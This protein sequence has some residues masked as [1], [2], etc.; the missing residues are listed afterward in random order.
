MKKFL[1]TMLA[2][3][4]GLMTLS[5]G[6]SKIVVHRGHWNTP[7]SAQNSIASLVKADSVG[8]DGS[9]FDVY[10]TSDDVLVVNH[11]AVFQGYK[12]IDTPSSII[13]NLVLD[14]GEKLP[15]LRQYLEAAKDLNIDLFMELEWHQT[16]E[17]ER[18]VARAA[19]DMVNE[20]GLASRTN[21]LSFSPNICNELSKITD[22]PVLQ[23][24]GERFTPEQAKEMGSTGCDFSVDMWTK[25]PEYFDQ[26]RD[27]GLST[28]VWVIDDRKQLVNAMTKDFDFI[29]TN[30]PE[31]AL[32]LRKNLYAKPHSTDSRD[33]Q[34]VAHRGY[35]NTPGSAQNS[36]ASLV[37]ADSVGA[38]ATEFDVYMTSDDV[39][40]LN[41]DGV[42]NGYKIVETPSTII[43]EQTLENGEKLPT[44]RQFLEV[45]K[46]LDIDL[47]LELKWHPTP[48]R[49][50]QAAKACVDMINEFGLSPRTQYISFS[51]TICN[52]LAKHTD[53]PV[54]HL[55]GEQVAPDKAK[56]LGC[57]GCDYSAG[58]WK[59]NPAM[60]KQ[61]RDLD[62]LT[63]IWTIDDEKQLTYALKNGFDYITT[64]NPVLAKQ[65]REK[66]ASTSPTGAKRTKVVAH[67]GYWTVPGSAQNSIT[68]LVKADSVGADASEFDVYMTSDDVL[69]LNHDGL[70]N[71]HWVTST[72]S[73]II[74]EQTLE[75]GEKLPTLRQFLDVA[76]DLD[77]DLVL[78]VKGHSTPE[79]ERQVA[80]AC[81]DMINE[82]GLSHR[83]QYISFSSDVCEELAKHTDR[84]VSHLWGQKCPPAEAKA[85]GCT[86][87][88]YSYEAWEEMPEMYQ[89]CQDLGMLTNIWT[90]YDEPRMV[91]A[92]QDGMDFI[93]T[94][95]PEMAMKLRKQTQLDPPAEA[96]R[97]KVVAHRG[98]W[99]APG[100]AQN[101][102]R[103]LIK[104]DSIGADATEFDVWMCSDG[105]LVLN[106]DGVINGMSVQNT[107]SKI[108]RQQKLEN[109]ENVPTLE[110]FLKVA[111][112]L[113][114]DLVLEL[115][116]HEKPER[117]NEAIKKIMKLLKKNHLLD[118]TEFISFS[119]N[120]CREFSKVTDRPV[121][122]L[123]GQ[124]WSPEE[125]KANGCTGCDYAYDVWKSNPDY[126]QRC[127]DNGL[128]IN[129]WTL[130]TEKGIIE[131][132][133][134]GVDYMTTDT[135]ELAQEI[136]ARAYPEYRKACRNKSVREKK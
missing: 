43:C 45:A 13:C 83:T 97:P 121:L 119:E 69:V 59:S 49:E 86:G 15:T 24:W 133:N 128:A 68:S 78:E 60:F 106:H 25:Q 130:G 110:E 95:Y 116:V 90:V 8:A 55:W 81:V 16:P 5:A 27:L 62:L 127:R 57:T 70:I 63:N 51:S 92:F 96:K 17:R 117:E 99:A 104:A 103:S 101:S 2:A 74:C 135:P 41:H 36:I 79:R 109:G 88:D 113:D 91:K 23:L 18:Q 50:R 35:W 29:T 75:N 14:N 76:K 48:E 73:T 98:Y 102:I 54:S 120:A 38:D 100:S 40:V 12:I 39:L 136:V 82:Y 6:P 56:E 33:C 85:L 111:K 71:G 61:C 44:L 26:C 65:L 84:P 11:D 122:F 53:R 125:A 4:A 80:K 21:Y 89:Q 108:I 115:K 52:E 46:D 3:A 37:K 10:M 134:N 42:I 93:T 32:Q 20:M 94:N 30:D 129:I 64:N 77:I 107:P 131:S 118:R 114:I 132:I 87:C 124:K 67:R 105:V 112:K 22:R 58:V 28:G 1:L 66:T 123:W 126:M 31:Y 19:V 9:E 47:V 72:P 7:G 34:I